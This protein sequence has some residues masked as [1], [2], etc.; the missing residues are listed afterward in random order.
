MD[1]ATYC[2]TYVDVKMAPMDAIWYVVFN[3]EIDLVHHF[4]APTSQPYR[5]T[6][7]ICYT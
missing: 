4:M 5:S 2:D 3:L 6:C 1:L 7:G